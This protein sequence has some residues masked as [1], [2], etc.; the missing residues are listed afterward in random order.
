MVVPA[1]PEVLKVP[2]YF[3]EVAKAFPCL[4]KLAAQQN[5]STKPLQSAVN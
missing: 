5:Q 2:I 1:F 3:Q 4:A